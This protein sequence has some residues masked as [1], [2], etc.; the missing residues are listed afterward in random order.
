MSF[1]LR[2]PGIT[3]IISSVMLLLSLFVIILGI[4]AWL[5]SSSIWQNTRD[6]YEH[7]LK[8]RRALWRIE[9][10]TVT[11]NALAA[12]IA[13]DGMPT[14]VSESLARNFSLDEESSRQFDELFSRY[15]GPR[16][17]V[18]RAFDAFNRWRSLRD[19]RG[20]GYRVPEAGNEELVPSAES[21][22]AAYRTFLDAIG[23]ISDFSA[24][25]SDSFYREAE[26]KKNSILIQLV[27]LT[28]MF[29][30]ISIL[31]GYLLLR[32][33]SGPLR[34]LTFMA[35]SYRKGDFSVSSGLERSDELGVLAASFDELADSIQAENASKSRLAGLASRLLAVETPEDFGRELLGTLMGSTDACAGAFY[36]VEEKGQGYDLQESAGFTGMISRRVEL[37]ALPAEFELAMSRKV[38][39]VL[40]LPVGSTAWTLH[41]TVGDSLPSDLLAIPVPGE[42]LVPGL[43]VLAFTRIP[44]QHVLALAQDSLPLISSRLSG[45]LAFRTTRSLAGRLETANRELEE[46]KRELQAQT[47]ELGE[48]NRELEVQKR[49]LDEASRLKS[50]FLATM[51]HELRTPLNSVIALSGV[52]TKKLSGLVPEREHS[53]LMAIERNGRHLLDLINDILDLSRIESGKEKL[54]HQQFDMAELITEILQMVE[55]EAARKK[56]VLENQGMAGTMPWMGDRAKIRHILQNLVANAVKFTEKGKVSVE[57]CFMAGDLVIS[58]R[59]TGIGIA[60]ADR[61]RIFEEFRQ[62]DERVARKFGGTG[63]GLSI[64]RKYALMMGGSIRVESTPGKGSVFTVRIPSESPERFQ[65]RLPVV[66]DQPVAIA[67]VP[68]TPVPAESTGEP[69][70]SGSAG[71]KA[72]DIRLLIVEDSEPAVIQLRDA[73]DDLG[74]SIQVAKNGREAMDTIASWAPTAL[75]LDLMMPEVD[76]FTVLSELRRDPERFSLPVLVLTARHPSESEREF[77]VRHGISRFIRKG[78]KGREGIRAAVRDL[79]QSECRKASLQPS[80][81]TVLSGSPEQPHF[82]HPVPGLEVQNPNSR[83]ERGKTGH[84]ILLVEDNDDN[85]LALKAMLPATCRLERAASAETAFELARTYIPDLVFMDISLPEVDGIGA[86]KRLRIMPGYES[87]PVVALTAR[88]M[89]GDREYLLGCG[90]DDYVSKPVEALI[91]E[92]CLGRFLHEYR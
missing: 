18:E 48:Q 13:E 42:P 23:K 7:P 70:Q 53:W 57:S 34:R 24:T 21:V 61:E 73:L 30:F 19:A 51:S 77:L 5:E 80:R 65:V 67:S 88:A 28:G 22:A 6:L 35:E 43:L 2:R 31:T 39:V 56:L 44:G 85:V 87:V 78:D 63:L 58:V 9:V 38:P 89:K 74:Y 27:V 91:L 71:E 25:K 82:S 4:V 92:K 37:S 47:A 8:V 50:T 46:Q 72:E 55:P 79:V 29:V 86:M 12:G 16:A 41:T 14:G 1:H 17:D 76:G 26:T 64:A 32:S 66:N 54:E 62:G 84:S 59:D 45:I 81:E 68:G 69:M 90:F 10:N 11:S 49:G 40:P 3:V 52:L 15:L 20:R 60:Q 33:V 75:L 83:T 36:L